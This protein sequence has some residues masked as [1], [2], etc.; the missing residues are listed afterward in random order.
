MQQYFEYLLRQNNKVIDQGVI[1]FE[2]IARHGSPW[3]LKLSGYHL[4]SAINDFHSEKAESYGREIVNFS[5]DISEQ[6]RINIK[7]RKQEHDK[8]TNELSNLLKE[9]IAEETNPKILKYIAQ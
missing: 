7:Q 1:Q 6:K 8:R 2:K 3:Y 9:L 4:L 5:D